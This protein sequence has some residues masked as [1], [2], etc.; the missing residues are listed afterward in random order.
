MYEK[1]QNEWEYYSHSEFTLR[2]S[3][4]NEHVH[5]YENCNMFDQ[6]NN[7]NIKDLNVLL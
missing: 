7:I 3:V 5:L 2:R 4:L 6:V 1:I